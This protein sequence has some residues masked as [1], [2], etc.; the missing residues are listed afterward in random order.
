MDIDT[1]HLN[2]NAAKHIGFHHV[3]LRSG[4]DPS[5]IRFELC[6]T[7]RDVG[8]YKDIALV[9]VVAKYTM[10]FL[11]ATIARPILFRQFI[12]IVG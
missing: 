8:N 5:E 11:D 2:Y 3:A 1:K 7:F 10:R 9:A 4:H 6:T 12:K